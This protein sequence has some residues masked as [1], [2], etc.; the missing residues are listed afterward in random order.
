[1]RG[2]SVTRRNDCRFWGVFAAVTVLAPG[3][4]G[5]ADEVP[6]P[7]VFADFKEA[8]AH[9]EPRKQK[10]FIAL[11]LTGDADS[12]VLATLIQESKLHLH[13]ERM[14]IYEY[15]VDDAA[16]ADSF[17]SHFKIT[18]SALPLVVVTDGS[19]KALGHQAG[20]LG[21]FEY[22]TFIENSAGFSALSLPTKVRI[23]RGLAASVAEASSG[24]GKYHTPMRKWTLVSGES[25][26][27]AVLQST[28]EH[29]VFEL[30]SGD[31]KEVGATTLSRPDFEYLREA[32][33]KSQ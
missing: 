2:E 10:V 9:A 1:M 8:L 27:G 6:E 25:F 13:G 23:K 24:K 12:E 7:K 18:D 32:L 31:L 5:A 4:S 26:E 33:E 28:G 14:V 22:Y 17:R 16:R 30:A 20:L 21:E 11:M 15:S 29:V 3:L 19:G